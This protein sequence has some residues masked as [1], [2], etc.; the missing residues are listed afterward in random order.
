MLITVWMAIRMNET[1]PKVENCDP[2]G[3]KFCVEALPISIID[4]S[5]IGVN[6]LHIYLFFLYWMSDKRVH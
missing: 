1:K 4:V 3:Q 5:V 2:G 6:N